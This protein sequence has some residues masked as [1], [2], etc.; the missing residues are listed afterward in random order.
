[1]WAVSLDLSTTLSVARLAASAVASILALA[2]S[3]KSLALPLKSFMPSPFVGALTPCILRQARYRPNGMRIFGM[4]WGGWQGAC[5][6]GAVAS[7]D[8]ELSDRTWRV[9][10]GVSASFTG[11]EIVLRVGD[12]TGHQNHA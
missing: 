3:L 10:A 5:L 6:V 2:L 7:A 8:S 9:L 12:F 11:D 1:M 4:R